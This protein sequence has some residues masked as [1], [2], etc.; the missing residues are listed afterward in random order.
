[1]ARA[2]ANAYFGLPLMSGVPKHVDGRKGCGARAAITHCRT[3][4]L[5]DDNDQ[6]TEAGINRLAS[7]LKNR[8]EQKHASDSAN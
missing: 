4:G 5:I 2:M 1:M 3:Q 6:L 7:Y 8:K